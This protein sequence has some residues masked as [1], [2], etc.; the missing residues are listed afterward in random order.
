MNGGG[1]RR[2]L[3]RGHHDVA[4]PGSTA[5]SGVDGYAA[6]SA[7]VDGGPGGAWDAEEEAEDATEAECG[8]KGGDAGGLDTAMN[9]A[10]DEA[11][12][13]GD[14]KREVGVDLEPTFLAEAPE[15]VAPV[16]RRSFVVDLADGAHVSPLRLSGSPGAI[17]GIE[18]REN[19]TG[20]GAVRQQ[21]S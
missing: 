2:R 18:N 16:G 8:A 15:Q 11:D 5:G 21:E 6:D 19:A 9:P 1:G 12:K 10:D 20:R 14:G 3:G 13:N 17:C 7:D 4:A